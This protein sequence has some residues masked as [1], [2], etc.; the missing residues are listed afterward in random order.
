MSVHIHIHINK[1]MSCLK[2]ETPKFSYFNCFTRT[3]SLIISI[4]RR[5]GLNHTLLSEKQWYFSTLFDRQL[6]VVCVCF[7][8]TT[9]IITTT[10]T[11]APTCPE[12]PD[13]PGT[14]TGQRYP[15][16]YDCSKYYV[17]FADCSNDLRDC[18]PGT[19]F[20]YTVQE[21]IDP[22]FAYCTGTRCL[23]NWYFIVVIWIFG[24]VKVSIH[25]WIWH[26]WPGCMFQVNSLWTRIIK[27]WRKSIT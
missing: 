22:E 5:W 9:T 19:E 25:Q 1:M 18:S 20:N 6:V 10:T 11:E 3:C 4:C 26:K 2:M 8:V 15:Y 12:D 16:P 13:N 24:D 23:L 27:L 21:C 7:Q 17:C 14:C